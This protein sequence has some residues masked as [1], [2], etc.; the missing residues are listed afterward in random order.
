MGVVDVATVSATGTRSQRVAR[1]FLGYLSGNRQLQVGLFIVVGII[2]IGLLAPWIA[3][4]SPT[5]TSSNVLSPPGRDHFFGTDSSGLDIFSRVLYAP[6]VDV[7][8]AVTATLLAM[9]V[10]VPIGIR[11]GFKKGILSEGV[12]RIFDV[13]QAFPFFILAITLL[14][15]FGPSA[16]NIVVVIAFVNA[17]IYF[18]LMRGQAI[19]LKNRTFVEAA[20]VA[21]CR[22]RDLMF[23]HVLPNALPPA[24]A[25]MSITIAWA[26]ILTAGVSFVGAGIRAP[27]PEWGVMIAAGA[28]QM[29]LGEW[30]PA[31]FP[32]LT[33]A[34]SVIGYGLVA[35][36]LT[37]LSDP[38]RRYG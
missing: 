1:A 25:Q 8:V 5:S 20:R 12:S 27:T 7:V 16:S 35:N 26:I 37:D 22:D 38:R 29:I 31:V 18:R 19:D 3:P 2:V 28:P 17:P 33:L 24:L 6:R 11:A 30:W 4:Y 21:G 23:R 10:G 13:V 32:G 14:T 34:V 9:A 15:A 36:A